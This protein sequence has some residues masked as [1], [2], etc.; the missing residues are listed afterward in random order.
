MT[1]FLEHHR[2]SDIFDFILCVKFLTWS[3]NFTIYHKTGKRDDLYEFWESFFSFFN[4]ERSFYNA[5][6]LLL[7]GC[8]SV[9]IL[10]LIPLAGWQFERAIRYVKKWT[11]SLKKSAK[12]IDKLKKILY[13]INLDNFSMSEKRFH[14][15]RITYSDELV[16]VI[17]LD[18]RSYFLLL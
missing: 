18:L 7:T 16:P 6:N 4:R 11:D 15:F 8:A 12:I 17:L 10:N 9:T 5:C 3:I 13:L 2:I 1:I 14:V